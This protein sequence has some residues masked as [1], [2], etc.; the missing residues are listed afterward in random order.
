M[1][2]TREGAKY[3][4]F[5]SFLVLNDFIIKPLKVYEFTRV[6]FGKQALF[7]QSELS[8]FRIGNLDILGPCLC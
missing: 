8:L 6:L 7:S 1:V 3:C 2:L 4:A 5:I